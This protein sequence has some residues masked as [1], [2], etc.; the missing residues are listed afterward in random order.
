MF[1][2]WCVVMVKV[3]EICNI[4]CCVID[5][6]CFLVVMLLRFIISRLVW[7]DR[8][9]NFVIWSLSFLEYVNYVYYDI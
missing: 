8:W 5:L 6:W 9:K 1:L 7:R 4:R 3:S 2:L